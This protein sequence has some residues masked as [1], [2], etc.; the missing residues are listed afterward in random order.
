MASKIYDRLAERDEYKD[1]D[2]S[3]VFQALLDSAGEKREERRRREEKE[4][5]A[6]AAVGDIKEAAR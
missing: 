3:V 6:Q 1:K 2:F 4:G 5:D